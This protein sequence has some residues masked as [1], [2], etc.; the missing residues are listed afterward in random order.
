M[1]HI[2]PNKEMEKREFLR[3]SNKIITSLKGIFLV[4]FLVFSLV[5]VSRFAIISIS[6]TCSPSPRN[7]ALAINVKITDE[8]FADNETIQLDTGIYYR[9]SI[10]HINITVLP[11]S[12]SSVD[13]I[14]S[15]ALGNEFSPALT[16]VTLAPGESFSENYTFIIRT[17]NEIVY[18]CRCTTG[19]NATILWSYEVLYSAK[20][21]GF[22]GIDFLFIGGAF[23]LSTLVLVLITKKKSN[24]KNG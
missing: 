18:A 14:C 22:I 23:I 8:L 7:S 16:N 15:E 17:A 10:L 3:K 13:I 12:N 20:P 6:A 11:Q 5:N 21:E 1:Y 19:P 24:K 4:L 2:L 9:E